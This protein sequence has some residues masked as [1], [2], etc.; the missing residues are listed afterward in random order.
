VTK[1]IKIKFKVRILEWSSFTHQSPGSVSVGVA[2]V[3]AVT[4]LR[5]RH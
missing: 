5:V 2:P 3:F 1:N 4:W